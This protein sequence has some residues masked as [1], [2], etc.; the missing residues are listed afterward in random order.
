MARIRTTALSPESVPFLSAVL[1]SENPRARAVTCSLLMQFGSDA[2]AAVPEL[3]AAA[4]QKP[5]RPA[6]SAPSDPELR[7]VNNLAIEALGRIAPQTESAALAITALRDILRVED[8]STWNTAV[9]AVEQFG[10][11][12]LPVVPELIRGL[13][14][15]TTAEDTRIDGYSAARALGRIAPGTP[16]AEKSIAALSEALAAGP[17][18][19]RYAVASALGEFGAASARAIPDLIRM[20]KNSSES[21]RSNADGAAI[22][23]G[24]IAPGTPLCSE[25][26]AALCDALQMKSSMTRYAAAFALRKFG[27]ESVSATGKLRA[28]EQDPEATV[29]SA[30]A[31]TLAELARHGE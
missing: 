6:E 7:D 14:K 26:V 17:P 20:L 3:I 11:A 10:R 13:H 4:R 18:H 12:A 2:R 8:P 25:A 19:I 21:E 31:E 24:R 9:Y 27:R 28:M 29:R 5:G 23:L 16:A 15:T 1:R 22:A 30:A